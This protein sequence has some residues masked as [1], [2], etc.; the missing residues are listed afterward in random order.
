M[1][2]FRFRLSSFTIKIYIDRYKVCVLNFSN[3]YA[4]VAYIYDK[5]NNNNKSNKSYMNINNMIEKSGLT[6]IYFRFGF[7][8]KLSCRRNIKTNINNASGI[9]SLWGVHR[10]TTNT[11]RDNKVLTMN[12]KS[13]KVSICDNK[14]QIPSSLYIFLND[15]LSAIPSLSLPSTSTSQPTTT[16]QSRSTLKNNIMK[17]KLMY[18]VVIDK[19][20]LKM[21]INNINT[22]TNNN[23]NNNF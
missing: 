18:A 17:K 7:D 10:N 6:Q 1:S 12:M 16:S 15:M 4:D 8:M 23:N 14:D 5:I 21:V 19:F 3:L 20:S 13:V 2:L 22:T 11:I 9:I